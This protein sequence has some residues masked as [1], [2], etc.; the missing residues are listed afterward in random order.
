MMIT[1]LPTSFALRQT[2]NP[3]PPQ[4][5]EMMN[6]PSQTTTATE[7]ED[8]ETRKKK[9]SELPN[10]RNEVDTLSKTLSEVTT[11]EARLVD[12]LRS[13]KYALELTRSEVERRQRANSE[14]Q[15]V[16]HQSDD[17]SNNN[18]NIEQILNEPYTVSEQH[19]QTENEDKDDKEEAIA[20]AEIQHEEVQKLEGELLNAKRDAAN[21]LFEVE[22]L[23]FHLKRLK[24]TANTLASA[25]SKTEK[26]HSTCATP[27]PPLV[28]PSSPSNVGGGQESPTTSHAHA[29]SRARLIGDVDALV[30]FTDTDD[31][32]EEEYAGC[33][34][35]VSAN[36]SVAV[37][38]YASANALMGV[39]VLERDDIDH[40]SNSDRMALIKELDAVRVAV[41]DDTDVVNVKLICGLG[42]AVRSAVQ[43]MQDSKQIFNSQSNDWVV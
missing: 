5:T 27:P 8:L 11:E 29:H 6:S 40:V 21:V 9:A 24:E 33:R 7:E 16:Y 41:L 20:T 17:N 4:P 10:L 13:L 31:A 3:P 23:E 28:I 32:E 43:L 15:T 35:G 39:D 14:L 25:N 1:P 36:G 42:E 30:G 38:S 34:L 22:N 12:Q 26:K 18:N 37:Y 19:Y 2:R